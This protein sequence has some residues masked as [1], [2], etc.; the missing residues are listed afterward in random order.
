MIDFGAFVR[1][2]RQRG[3][4]VVQPRMGFDAPARMRSGLAATKAADATTIGTVTLDSYTRVGD[5]GA[6]VEALR[7][8]TAL[9]GYPIVTHPPE[10]TAEVLA[11]IR[12][13]TFP[14]QVRHGSASPGAIFDALVTLRLGATEGGPVSY[15]LPYG[16]TSLADSVRNWT[17]ATIR[18]ACLREH[19]IEPHLET[20]G[21]CMLGQLCPPSLLVALSA[22]EALFFTRHGIRSVSLSYAQQTHP[23]QD[24]EAVLALRRLATELLPDIDWHVV[25]YA[26]MGVYPQTDEGAH[27]LLGQAAELAVHTGSERLIV[28]TVA[29][30]RRIPTIEENVAAI[31]Y[32]AAVARRLVPSPGVAA[33]GT[34]QTYRE[35]R[36]LIEAALA[37]AAEPGRA[38]LAAFGRGYLDVPYCLHPDNAGRSRSYLDTQGRLCWARVGAMPLGDLVPQA[39][40]DVRITSSGLLADL[41]YVR[42][43]F[44]P[45]DLTSQ[46]NH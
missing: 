31:E 3:E 5:L 27:R 22:L 41:S 17:E 12:D 46:L 10:V 35:A 38:L 24:T 2:A 37:L 36:A 39:G 8:G 29:E 18:F 23:G 7:T 20:F 1:A 4:L 30:S 19:G 21:G 14:V 44:D 45:R 40:P 33:D 43:V 28:K 34:S 6:V 42:R 13:D 15:C 26:Y 16:R 11:C 9:N 32:A 25:I